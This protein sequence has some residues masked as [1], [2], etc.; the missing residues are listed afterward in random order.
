MCLLMSHLSLNFLMNL[1]Q[2]YMVELA[3]FL[4]L[5]TFKK[6]IPEVYEIQSWYTIL[7]QLS[8]KL[9]VPNLK[10]V[11]VSF[12]AFFFFY[13]DIHRFYLMFFFSMP[14]FHPK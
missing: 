8:M 7:K 12:S 9:R 1:L 13:S 5:S 2:M 4:D 11:E 3:K 10:G 14:G 6:L